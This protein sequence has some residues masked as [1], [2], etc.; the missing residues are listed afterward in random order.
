[1]SLMLITLSFLFSF[2]FSFGDTHAAH[3]KQLCRPEQRDLLLEFK[4]EFEISKSRDSCLV[5]NFNP[6]PMESWMYNRDCCDWD[7][8]T[9]DLK[10]GE[11][12]KLDLSFSCLQGRFHS[13]TSLFK[14]RN[15]FFLDTL[16]LSY[17]SLRG[18]V[19]SLIGNLSH[20]T[21]LDL[22]NNLFSGGI[23]LSIRNL[24]NLTALDLSNNDFSGEISSI[25]ENL[26]HLT[27]LV[28]SNNHFV[29]KI[30]F[31]VGNLSLLTIL[32]LE[33]NDFDGEVPSSFGSLKRLNVLTL[34]ANNLSGKFPIALLN[35]T[36]L[37]ILGI[38]Y[39]HFTGT[40]PANINS[41]S[42]LLYFD[43]SVNSFTGTLPSSLFAI[44]SLRYLDMSNNLLSGTLEFGNVSLPSNLVSL[45]LGNNNLRGP[46]PISISKLVNLVILNISQFNMQGPVDFSIFSQIK[47][48]KQ[49]YLSHLKTTTTIDLNA[50]LSLHLKSISML[51]LS[52]NHVSTTNKSSAIANQPLQ[53]L[54][55]LL[56]SDCGI[57]EFPEILRS[58]EY[59]MTELDVSNNKIKGQVPGWLWKLIHF[60][61]LSNN[62]FSGFERPT[63]LGQSGTKV[64][65][66]FASDNNFTGEIPSF[67][68]S[69]LSLNTL[70]LS[71]NNFNG[72]ILRCMGNLKSNLSRLILR[73]NR[74]TGDLPENIYGNLI[75]LDVGHNQLVGKLP[76][77]L[78]HSLTLE[79]LNVGSNRI[80]DSFPFWLSSLQ[81][82]QIL[83]LRSNAFH[84]PIHKTRFA[85]LRIMDISHNHFNGTLPSDFFVSWTA[86]SSLGKNEVEQH[87]DGEK[88]MGS[89]YY[90]D[91]MVLMSKGVAMELVRILKIYTAIDFS[92]NKFEGEIPKSIGLLKELHVLNLS[93]N[94]FD[95][96]IPSSLANLTELESLDVSQNK[97]S[98]GI[99]QGLGSLSYL[100]HMNFSHNHL[101]GLVPGGTQFRTQK[102]SSFGKNSGLFG[103]SLDEACRDTNTSTPQRHDETLETEE[104]HEEVLS[105]VA[106][107]VGFVPGIIFGFTIGCILISYKPEWFM[108]I[109]GRRKRT[110]ISTTT[111]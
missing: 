75:S 50:V 107:A 68:C 2:I 63:R 53:G 19:L 89:L 11:V 4:N 86:M 57:T 20:L 28:L 16:N 59:G 31:S 71:N 7:G 25:T 72:P 94:A 14:L 45:F 100:S 35:L 79:V 88:Y 105:W 24:S 8:I 21:S 104:E 34:K 37:S 76:R 65:H 26:P 40:F 1:M 66:L 102:C 36:E 81:K 13:N 46:I 38:S 90:H 78:V 41:L 33:H 77:S 60:V 70:D 62:T 95:G 73:Q 96:H 30:P 23:P 91:S 52:G 69:L 67:I 44:S 42:N 85:K 98:G 56:L 103:P 111:R 93:T 108:N 51:D 55:S 58:R 74:L 27:T 64:T 109:F 22:S 3:T 32:G 92:G 87:D 47:G 15:L 6:I 97:L 80:N 49:L 106:A 18:E 9:C 83:V 110:R 5:N 82:L 39:N 48:L 61:N 84:G 17:N 10:S 12:I 101:A 99:P 43:A 54:S 29:G